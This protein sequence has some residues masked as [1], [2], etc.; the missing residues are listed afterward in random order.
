[1]NLQPTVLSPVALPLALCFQTITTRPIGKP[2]GFY[3]RTRSG[4]RGFPEGKI[5]GLAP[6]VFFYE[7]PRGHAVAT[8]SKHVMFPAWY[9]RFRWSPVNFI[10][11]PH[12]VNAGGGTLGPKGANSGSRKND[13]PVHDNSIPTGLHIL[14][15]VS[16]AALKIAETGFEPVFF[17]LWAKR[18]TTSPLRNEPSNLPLSYEA[19]KMYISISRH[20]M[21]DIQRHPS[22]ERLLIYSGLCARSPRIG[23]PYVNQILK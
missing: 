20:W 11:S 12:T 17:W 22:S 6:I 10:P 19:L 15:G 2:F 3:I 5:K 7:A 14:S 18:D 21:W 13:P 9:R 1:M 8:C 16:G 4:S 23:A